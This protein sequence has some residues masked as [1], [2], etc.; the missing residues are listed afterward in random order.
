MRPEFIKSIK[1]SVRTLQNIELRS[2]FND[3]IPLAKKKKKAKITRQ[4]YIKLKKFLFG[5]RNEAKIKRHPI[6]HR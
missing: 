2:I 6:E 3:S 1:E 4:N 5:E